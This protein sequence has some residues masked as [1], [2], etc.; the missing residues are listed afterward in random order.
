MVSGSIS[1]QRVLL[2]T[3]RP[4]NA[5]IKMCSP[6]CSMN[7]YDIVRLDVSFTDMTLESFAWSKIV[8]SF[9]HPEDGKSGILNASMDEV[10]SYKNEKRFRIIKFIHSEE[11]GDSLNTK[12]RMARGA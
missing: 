8:D 6:N 3:R 7:D 2:S 12:T 11:Q 9:L 10:I 1:L 4:F 5:V